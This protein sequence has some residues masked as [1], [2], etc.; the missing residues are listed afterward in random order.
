MA[1]ERRHASE[2]STKEAMYA[3]DMHNPL[4]LYDCLLPE[5][6]AYRPKRVV[7]HRKKNLE[8]NVEA[9]T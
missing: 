1:I 4:Q 8:T 5:I 2:S 7:L 9:M 6:E 3:I